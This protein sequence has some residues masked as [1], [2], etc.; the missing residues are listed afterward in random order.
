MHPTNDPSLRSFLEISSNSDFPIQNLPFGVFSK[1]AEDLHRIGVRIGDYVL[2]LH[3]LSGEGWLSGEHIGN[4][5]VFRRPVLNDFMALGKQA[6]EEART[7]ISELLREDNAKLR[8]DK[9]MREEVLLP[10]ADVQMHLPA[11][12]GDYTDFYASKYHATNVGTMFRGPD[13]ALQPNYLHLPV[14]YH[15]RASSVVVSGTDLHRP[16]GQTIAPDADSPAFGPCKLLD[17]ELEVGVFVGTG[18]ELGSPMTISRARDSIFG[19]VLMNDWSARD[20][21]KW[22]YV[23]LGPFLSKNFGTS[24][25]PWIVSMTALEP[26]LV[27]GEAQDPEPLPYLKD[28]QP[29]G[30]N[31][32]LEALVQTERMASPYRITQTNMKYLYWTIYQQLTHHAVTGCNLRPGDLF[33]TG[34]V[35]GPSKESRACLLELT[36]RGQEPLDLPSGESRKFLLDGDRLIIK[37]WGQANGYNIGFGEVIGTIL[38]AVESQAKAFQHP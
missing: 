19:L 15:G 12:I 25:S 10:I 22:E 24:I 28:N 26:F 16:M 7:I 23:P 14:G 31:L 17:Y 29:G 37:G 11:S 13:N 1:T 20:I 33:G 30:F 34:T 8:D 9:A 38:P 6:W 18:N 32:H 36:W 5:D 3:A 27:D 35:S 21:Q 4:G 2:D